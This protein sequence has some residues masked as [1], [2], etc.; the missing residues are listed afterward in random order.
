MIVNLRARLQQT[1]AKNDS[2]PERKKCLVL[3]ERIPLKEFEGILSV[4]GEDVA[5]LGIEMESPE[6]S[7]RNAVFLDTETTGLRGAGTVAFLVGAGKIVGD[8]FVLRQYFMRDYPEEEDLLE[9]LAGWIE[10][11]GSI[12]TFNG[13]SFDWP[14]LRDRYVINR[15]RELWREI[16]Q[17]DL[18][19]PARRTWKSRLGSCTL[20]HLEQ[21]ALGMPERQ[22][23]LPGSQV[24]ERYFLFL[25]CRDMT[26]MDDVLRHNAQDIK[27]LA[28][29]LV[30]LCSLY[31]APETAHPMD[32][33][34]MG[35]ALERQKK[36]ILARRCFQAAMAPGFQSQA[37]LALAASFRKDRDWENAS[38]L[39]REM[40]FRGEGGV[41]AYV[42]LAILQEWRM[43][44]P[45]AA[46]NTTQ[47]ALARYSGALLFERVDE[48]ALELLEKRR[49]RLTKK[50]EAMKRRKETC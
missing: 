28:Q 42:S 50:I 1:A 23:D 49:I 37:R 17:I 40:I 10:N 36:T 25:K 2:P 9:N 46:L 12:V 44:E 39:Y 5:R 6:F 48:E 43:K 3:E 35:R 38:R 45:Q 27:S 47:A 34:S 32:A 8:E 41:Q 4:G 11:A 7:A 13:K 19:H 21:E 24:P 15:K 33:L 14:L 31:S 16:P 18:I 26:L 30:R 29:L 20:G 22:G